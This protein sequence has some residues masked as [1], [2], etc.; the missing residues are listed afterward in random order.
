MLADDLRNRRIADGDGTKGD[1]SA[2]IGQ[3]QLCVFREIFR[4]DDGTRQ[5]R[6]VDGRFVCL[7]IL[8]GP[9]LMLPPLG[10]APQFFK[11]P[12]ACA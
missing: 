12:K 9:D 5:I 11:R 6:S 8:S 2:D 3:G 7:N 1:S 4:I 10:D